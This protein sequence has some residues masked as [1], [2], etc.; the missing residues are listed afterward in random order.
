VND[1]R[2]DPIV[3][4]A[5]GLFHAMSKPNI[6]SGLLPLTKRYDEKFYQCDSCKNIYWEGRHHAKMQRLVK[7]MKTA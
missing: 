7:E 1:E 6:K 3:H 2:L 4:S 5:M